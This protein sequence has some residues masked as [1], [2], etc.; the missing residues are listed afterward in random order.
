M[1]TITTTNGSGAQEAAEYFAAHPRANVVRIANQWTANGQPP[2]FWRYKG[3]RADLAEIY[4]G[5]LIEV[6]E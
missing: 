2:I 4:A 3:P 6:D 1:H 5:M